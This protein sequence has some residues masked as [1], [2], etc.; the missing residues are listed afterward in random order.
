MVIGFIQFVHYKYS[1]FENQKV[2]M[3]LQNMMAFD[4]VVD[5]NSESPD[6]IR[7][8]EIVED[9][10]D[11]F[12]LL[13][14]ENMDFIGWIKIDDTAINYPVVKAYDYDYYLTH[15]FYGKENKYG[16][17]FVKDIADIQTPGTNFVVYGHNMKN[18][19]MFGSLKEYKNIKY[20]NKHPYV[21]FRMQDK[22]YI[23]DIVAAFETDALMEDSEEYPY[24]EFYE[25]KTQTDFDE[26]YNF[27]KEKSFY[28][29]GID[30]EYGDRFITLSTCS[31]KG[32]DYRF[33][34]VGKLRY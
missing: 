26:F 28:D 13:L 23:Y 14:E 27:I 8:P 10:L 15:D 19:A 24:Y 4:H 31:S 17:I 11:G 25:A 3:K 21:S 12:E 32:D 30:A 22:S 18:G 2:S 1:T 7:N 9:T 16:C 20:Y 33:I 34:V 29:T 6:N 5:G